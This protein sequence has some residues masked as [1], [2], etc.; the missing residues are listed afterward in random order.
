MLGVFTAPPGVVGNNLPKSAGF[1]LIAAAINT[2]D[3]Q[4]FAA[5]D[6]A[7][8]PITVINRPQIIVEYDLTKVLNLTISSIS[9]QFDSAITA[10]GKYDAAMTATLA[11]AA[12]TYAVPLYVTTGKAV[13]LNVGVQ[14]KNTVTRDDGEKTETLEAPV[15]DVALGDSGS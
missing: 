13:R 1:T 2:S 4:T 5:Y 11:N 3:G 7:A 15:L 8:T 10:T 12:A 6:G 14:W 9:V